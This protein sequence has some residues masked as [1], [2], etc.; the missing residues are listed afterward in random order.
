MAS[1]E[2]IDAAWEPTC[3]TTLASAALEEVGNSEPA[4]LSPATSSIFPELS[5]DL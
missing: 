2:E 3:E 1:G 4:D 5:L